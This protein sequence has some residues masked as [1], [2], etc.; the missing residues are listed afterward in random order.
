MVVIA[1]PFRGLGIEPGPQRPG[2]MA[3]KHATPRGPFSPLALHRLGGGVFPAPW[4]AQVQKL[5]VGAEVQVGVGGADMD[6]CHL[7]CPENGS[8]GREAGKAPPAG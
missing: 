3:K 1:D 8:H 6:S 5:I 2:I 4:V 7:E